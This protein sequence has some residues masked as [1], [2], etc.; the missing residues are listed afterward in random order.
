VQIDKRKID[1]NKLD[2]APLKKRSKLVMF[3]KSNKYGLLGTLAFHLVLM[4]IL[5]LFKLNTF[6]IHKETSLIIEY[7]E[8]TVVES[9]KKEETK[10]EIIKEEKFKAENKDSFKELL[11]SIAVNK[12]DKTNTSAKESIDKMISEIKS[13][14]HTGND[15]DLLIEEKRKDQKKD[16]II[17]KKD[18][19]V[20]ID[21]K[22]SNKNTFYSGPSSVFFELTGRNKV[23]LP[24]PVFKCEG[25]G[26]IVV[27]IKVNNKGIVKRA[28][29]LNNET[30]TIDKCLREAALEA[31]K[32][33]RFNI[34]LSS[35]TPQIGIINYTFIKQ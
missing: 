17:T 4:I 19:S 27:E 35:P 14:T 33:S 22:K 1:K 10:E 34:S 8:E 15:K 11:K 24:I 31:A 20:K 23:Y 5:M 7:I 21:K 30:K 16:S 28:R 26:N 18:L 9:D 13:E 2:L 25:E 6:K 12:A 29:I 3:L 32:E